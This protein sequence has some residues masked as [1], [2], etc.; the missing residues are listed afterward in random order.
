MNKYSRDIIFKICNYSAEETSCK[1]LG[2]PPFNNM[3]W[4]LGGGGSD[5]YWDLKP[6]IPNIWAQKGKAFIPANKLPTNNNDFGDTYGVV[7]LERGTDVVLSTDP[8][9]NPTKTMKVFFRRYDNNIH[10]NSVP[11]WF[12]YWKNAAL[13]KGLN[14]TEPILLATI[15]PFPQVGFTWNST[16]SSATIPIEF[17]NT[18]DFQYPTSKNTISAGAHSHVVTIVTE[19]TGLKTTDNRWQRVGIDHD[20]TRKIIIGNV[21]GYTKSELQ[22]PIGGGLV[23]IDAIE[24]FT[25][26]LLHEMYHTNVYYLLWPNGYDN[27]YDMDDDYFPDT[28]E[29]SNKS[30]G[31]DEKIKA[32]IYN[33]KYKFLNLSGENVRTKYEEEE[34]RKKSYKDKHILNDYDWSYDPSKKIEGYQWKKN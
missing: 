13:S 18:G 27:E 25:S 22:P 23:N 3:T 7:K 19:G 1:A 17:S 20:N 16:K 32:G 30:Y 11:N 9:P 5:N 34:C 8:A 31:F 4:K 15:N 6:L 21:N 33:D 24:A 14:N 10:D 29:I 28:F 12:Y 2:Q 26:T